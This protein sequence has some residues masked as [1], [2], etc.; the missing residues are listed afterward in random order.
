LHILGSG[1]QIRCYTYG[2]DLARGIRLA[3]ERPE[4]LNEDFNL[5]T[6]VAT[7]VLTLARMIWERINPDK[8]FRHVSDQP[9]VHDVQK[10]IPSVE[11]AKRL[12][13]FEATTPLGAILDE[14]IPWLKAEIAA[15]GVEQ[16][17]NGKRADPWLGMLYLPLSSSMFLQQLLP[18]KRDNN[19]ASD[20]MPSVRGAMD[21]AVLFQGTMPRDLCTTHVTM[22][23]EW[24][25]LFQ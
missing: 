20:G 4:A 10:R 3:I 14:V 12:L 7:D 13:G 5:S 18:R 16:T 6:S 21:W 17:I 2:G 19:F 22:H 15:G 11:K 1:E 9:F 24:L 25:L 8:P 23:G